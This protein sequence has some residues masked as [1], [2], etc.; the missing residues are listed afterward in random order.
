MTKKKKELKYF[1]LSSKEEEAMKVLWN[2]DKAL[3][4]M[5]IAEGIPDRS[6]P[7]MEEFSG[8]RF[9]Q[10]SMLLCNLNDFIREETG[11]A[12]LCFHLFWVIRRVRRR[13]L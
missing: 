5:E 9:L 12:F 10:M 4:A 6:W 13:R 2:S 7:S 11:T 8:L 3:S 1:S